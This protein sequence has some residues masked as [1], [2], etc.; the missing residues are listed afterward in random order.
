[1]MSNFPMMGFIGLVL[2]IV[3]LIVL[4]Y[5]NWN[6]FLFSIIASIV[7]LV[8]SGLP[9]Y[10]NLAGAFMDGFIAFFKGYF[11]MIIASAV[12]ARIM[13][14]TGAC[15]VICHKLIGLARRCKTRRGQYMV[16]ILSLALIQL[17]VTAGGINVFVVIF[18]LVGM[19]KDIFKEL[20]IPWHLAYLS[21]F[22]CNTITMTMLPGMPSVANYMPVEILG[23]TTMSGPL[24]GV[25]ASALELLMVLFYITFVVN[26]NL[27]TEERFLPTGAVI[28]SRNMAEFEECPPYS[29]IYV[30]IPSIVIIVLL[31]V[32]K[33]PAAIALTAGCI[34]AGILFHKTYSWK[35][36]AGSIEAGARDA[37]MITANVSAVVGFGRCVAITP[38][39]EAVLNGLN[40]MPGSP[41]I[42]LIIAVNVAAGLSGSSSG[43]MQ[44]AL[45]Q[46]A[47]RYIAQGMAPDVIH[48]L[49]CI[50]SGGLESLPHCGS[51]ISGFQ[52]FGVTHKMVYKYVFVETV[53]FPIICAFFAAFLFSLGLR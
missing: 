31:N 22:G 47:P 21:I 13:G 26:K 15:S 24:V 30:L 29:L 7:V 36:C 32:C 12:F 33:L 44:I 3:I 19:A 45:P 23:T 10:E 52:A 17:V 34:L 40:S 35:K 9:I 42:Q 14:D 27:K 11:L 53:I 43:G 38:A 4:A 48:R 41:M 16:A 28:D 1:M 51:I 18:L 49:A 20:D 25:L 2:G 8:F 5:R 6:V 39:Y 37:V 50:S 46:L